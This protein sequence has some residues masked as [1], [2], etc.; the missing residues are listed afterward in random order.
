MEREDLFSS[1]STN[2]LE[3]DNFLLG[4]PIGAITQTGTNPAKLTHYSETVQE[5]TTENVQE[6]TIVEATIVDAQEATTENVQEVVKTNHNKNYIKMIDMFWLLN[7]KF[8][9]SKN[10]VIGRNEAHFVMIS[11]NIIFGNLRISYHSVDNETIQGNIVYSDSL[12]KKT[13]VVGTIYPASLFK[14]GALQVGQSFRCIE[15]L[16]TKTGEPWQ[17]NRPI[18]DVKREI[19]KDNKDTIIITIYNRENNTSS[20]YE[21]S[22]WQKEALIHSA[23]FAITSGFELTG[24]HVLNREK[25]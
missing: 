19:L 14:L 7:E 4:T 11:Y 2:F 21:F 10:G 25:V 5:V 6:A 24:Q 12:R 20:Y 23:R 8:V 9:N 18:T 3:S 22:G 1:F 16:F 13:L 15:Q 17:K